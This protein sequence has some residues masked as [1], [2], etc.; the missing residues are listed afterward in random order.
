MKDTRLSNDFISAYPVTEASL[1]AKQNAIKA[2]AEL[3][4]QQTKY[5]GAKRGFILS[6][7]RNISKAFWLIQFL[8]FATF[9]LNFSRASKLEDA[10]ILFLTIVPVMTFYILPELLKVQIYGT[11]ETEASCFFT[12]IKS[13]A[14]KM[15][16]VSVCNILIIGTISLAM[17]LY[18]QLNIRELLCCGLIPFN[19]SIALTII[20][21]DFIKITSPYAMLSVSMLLTVGL[22][23]M[24]RLTFLL[25]KAWWSIYWG[26]VAFVLLSIVIT[27]IRFNHTKGYYYGAKY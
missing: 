22:M 26:S 17:G 14:V 23:Q 13:L 18:H 16:L 15:I 10:Q 8:C 1:S 4:S 3:L 19:I 12:P 6:Q 7:L 25:Y 9:L 21:F 20:V 2:A 24:Q 5:A 27:A 11:G